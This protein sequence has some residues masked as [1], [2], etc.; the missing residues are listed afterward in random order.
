MNLSIKGKDKWLQGLSVEEA[1]KALQ[2]PSF[3]PLAP[4]ISGFKL[5]CSWAYNLI[6]TWVRRILHQWLSRKM[7][8]TFP[9]ER[10]LL[11][12]KGWRCWSEQ[13]TNRHRPLELSSYSLE[14]LACAHLLT[15]SSSLHFTPLAIQPWCVHSFICL[16]LLTNLP[17]LLISSKRA[18]SASKCLPP[19]NPWSLYLSFKIPELL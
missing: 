1:C 9:K 17:G 5:S 15:P 11:W 7:E 18:D 16:S 2:D 19:N 14:R 4:W 6:P 12:R 3:H 8:K 10:G 13:S